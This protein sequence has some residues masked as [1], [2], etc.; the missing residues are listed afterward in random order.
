MAAED[1]LIIGVDS[2][3]TKT[4]AGTVTLGGRLVGMGY[5]GATNTHFV[6]DQDAIASMRG[7]V[8]ASLGRSAKDPSPEPAVKA[9]YISAPGFPD[10]VAE[11]ALRDLCP[12]AVI[13]VEGDA[14]AA[15]RGALPNGDGIVSLSGTGSFAAGLWKG[16]WLTN[17]GWGPLLGD[18]GS[19][20]WIGLEALKAVALAADG[21]GPRTSLQGIFRRALHYSFDAELRVFVYSRYVNRQ[22][23]S[24]LTT[25]VAQAARDG[26]QIAQDILRRAGIELARL[27]ANLSERLGVGSEPVNISLV[28][29]VPLCNPLVVEAFQDALSR[30]VPQARYVSPQYEPWIGAIILGYELAQAE[31]T[32]ERVQAIGENAAAMWEAQ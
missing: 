1:T 17:G 19:G 7:A 6:S 16:K 13:K 26:D 21:R 10:A 29:G 32:P 15:F 23:I 11:M 12:N 2:G 22:R 14:P 5:G 28:G 31:V 4:I 9:I 3:G 18:E 24:A 25:L 8:A 30:M 27:A 20:Y